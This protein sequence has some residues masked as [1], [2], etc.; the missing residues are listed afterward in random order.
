LT[1]A[2]RIPSPP[3]SLTG[4]SRD[5]VIGEQSRLMYVHELLTSIVPC[6]AIN[7]F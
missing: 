7:T 5:S 2:M 6:V 1:I 3:N 4:S